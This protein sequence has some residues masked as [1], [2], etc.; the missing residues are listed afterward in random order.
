MIAWVTG[1]GTGIGRALAYRLSQEGSN[2]VITG[3]R[4]EMLDETVRL[5]RARSV[6]GQVMAIAGDA[7]DPVHVET[8]V[9]QVAQK[10]GPVDLLINNAGVNLD[11]GEPEA[12]F[13]R[14]QKSLEMNCLSAVRATEAVLPA[15]RKSGSGAIVNISSVYG[16]WSS[17]SSP[18]YSVS[19]YA[20]AGYTD[21]LRQ[22]LLGTGVHVMG[23]Y[24]GFIKTAM[25]LPFVQP[26]SVKAFSG[27]T[28]DQMAAALLYALRRK[29]RDL[30]Y[31]WYVSW[32]LRFQR[33]MPSMMDFAA[34][35]VK[36]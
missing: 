17:G 7:F 23:V 18:S 24:P 13:E 30:F 33:W 19:K 20:L 14:Y 29:K 12:T 28:P 4:P 26:G 2:V 10:W 25:T 3:R 11:S 8:V 22:R 1:G 34:Q 31:P 6:S 21:A 15:M 32:V 5:I 9:S 27:K 35:H 16:K 36:R